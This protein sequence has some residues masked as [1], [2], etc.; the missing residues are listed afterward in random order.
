MA[1]WKNGCPLAPIPH[2][3]TFNSIVA[4]GAEPWADIDALPSLCREM[5]Y[6]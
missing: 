6:W 5:T 1:D 2:T 3:F 4:R